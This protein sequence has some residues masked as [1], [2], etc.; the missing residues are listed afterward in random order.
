MRLINFDL[1]PRPKVI[2]CWLSSSLLFIPIFVFLSVSHWA[3]QKF[4]QEEESCKLLVEGEVWPTL[5]PSELSE[6]RWVFLH[7]VYFLSAFPHWLV[8]LWE[9]IHVR[10]SSAQETAKNYPF[11]FC[12]QILPV[13]FDSL[14]LAPFI[15]SNIMLQ[16]FTYYFRSLTCSCCTSDLRNLLSLF[17]SF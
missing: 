4:P 11:I 17:L 16:L 15:N 7:S 14:S 10:V 5:R 8:D 3:G 1:H 6:R 2:I 9:Q 12:F 13:S